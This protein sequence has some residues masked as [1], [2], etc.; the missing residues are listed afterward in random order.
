MKNNITKTILLA[1]L[2]SFGLNTIAQVAINTDGSEPDSSAILDIKSTDKGILIPR[3][4]QTEIANIVNPVDGLIVYNISDGHLYTYYESD[5]E[6]KE[7]AIGNGTITPTW[8]CG[9][10]FVDGRNS[11]SYTTV[12]IGTQCWMAENLNY[13]TTNSWWYDNSSAKGDVYGRLYTWES[14][15]NGL[16][17]RMEFAKR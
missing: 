13:E 7:I 15:L 2:I 14:S 4:T 1:L 5:S 17:K 6:W 16:P 12:Q 10:A 11:Q 9:D 8:A 3:M